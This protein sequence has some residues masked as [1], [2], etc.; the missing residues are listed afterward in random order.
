MPETEVRTKQA[1]LSARIGIGLR[2]RLCLGLG[3][4]A[5]SDQ[6]GLTGLRIIAAVVQRRVGDIVANL[7]A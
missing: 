6:D 7:S 1:T 3:W 5:A 2:N 4:N